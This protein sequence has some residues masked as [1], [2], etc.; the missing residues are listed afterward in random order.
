[1]HARTHTRTPQSRPEKSFI[2]A[3]AHRRETLITVYQAGSDDRV[4][5][6]KKRAAAREREKWK[7]D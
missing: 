2:D 5:Q 1:M 4:T 6:G 7:G 3:A